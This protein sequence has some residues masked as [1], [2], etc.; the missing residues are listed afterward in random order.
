MGLSKKKS[1]D[2]LME[3]YNKA[4]G[5][6][7]KKLKILQQA[8]KIAKDD[9]EKLIINAKWLQLKQD[10]RRGVTMV[11]QR[12]SW[13]QC[14]ECGGKGRTGLFGKC[15]RCEGKGGLSYIRIDRR[16]VWVICPKCNGEGCPRCYRKGGWEEVDLR[17]R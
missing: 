8:A 6:P 1:F 5:N 13:G 17:Q 14:P 16:R 7:Q 11:N 2:E 3:E 10:A 15:Q 9:K 4:F 12:R